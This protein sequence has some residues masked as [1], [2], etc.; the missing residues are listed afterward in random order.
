MRHF[1]TL[2][3][4][5]VLAAFSLMPLAC[6]EQDQSQAQQEIQSKPDAAAVAHEDHEAHDHD[7]HDDHDTHDHAEHLTPEQPTEQTAP[8]IAAPPASRDREAG[9][10]RVVVSIPALLWPLEDLIGEDDEIE[11]IVQPGQSVHGFELTPELVRHIDRA[12]LL[13]LVGLGVDEEVARAARNRP[14][15]HREV[16]VLA[17]IAESAGQLPA[18]IESHNHDGQGGQGHAH[19][20]PHIWLLPEVMSIFAID[21]GG[22]LERA[23]TKIGAWEGET[24]F[25][26][27]QDAGN[28]SDS[29]AIAELTFDARLAPFVGYG[30]VS[31]HSAFG[32]FLD[33][34][35]LVEHAIL[36]PNPEVEPTPGD[37]QKAVDAIREHN[38]LGI[39]VVPGHDRTAAE[40]VAEIT[41]VQIIEVESVGSGNWPKLMDDLYI[42]LY[43]ALTGV[44]PAPTQ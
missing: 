6:S 20:D 38:V 37:I 27:G 36:Q 12:D 28:A 9:P 33:R 1:H 7:D 44:P 30:I 2:L 5:A 31:N 16:V 35:G 42:A 18:G 24:Q 41:G 11:T 26:V 15:A 3:A 21:L 23:Y 29:A 40:R 22:I 43:T 14:S 17:E 19:A 13:V 25:R 4:T 39:L 10:L 32:L 34:F 8:S